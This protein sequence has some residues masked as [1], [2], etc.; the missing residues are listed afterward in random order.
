VKEKKKRKN[1]RMVKGMQ[2]LQAWSQE[3]ED[4]FTSTKLLG[5]KLLCALAD[6]W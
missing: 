5:A 6:K 1:K 2:G 4:L 3:T